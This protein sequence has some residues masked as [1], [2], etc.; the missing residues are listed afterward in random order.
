[1]QKYANDD[2]RK[3]NSVPKFAVYNNDL[4]SALTTTSFEKAYTTPDLWGSWVESAVG[5]HVLNMAD[6]Y[7][8]KVYYWRQN[9]D[10]VDFILLSDEKYVAIEMKS[11]RRTN[12]NGLPLFTEKFHP[13]HSFVVGSG[14]M[15]IDEFLSWDL[16]SLFD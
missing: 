9:S 4:L 8:F 15:P 2:A 11:G 13:I 10:E 7:D 3:Y 12:N 5:T 14:G 1:M 16:I 6:L